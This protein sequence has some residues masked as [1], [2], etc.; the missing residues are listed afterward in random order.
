LEIFVARRIDNCFGVVD[1]V[2]MGLTFTL[3]LDTTHLHVG[4]RS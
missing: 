3:H 1:R 2:A 4:Q